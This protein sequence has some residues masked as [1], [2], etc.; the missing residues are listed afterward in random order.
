M[1]DDLPKYK[2]R[3]R[4]PE[5]P[6][7]AMKA[8]EADPAAKQPLGLKAKCE[9]LSEEEAMTS[10]DEMLEDAYGAST[11]RRRRRERLGA[12]GKSVFA[13]IFAAAA[14]TATFL[15]AHKYEG[16]PVMQPMDW[17]LPFALSAALSA[18]ICLQS[19]HFW[20]D[21]S[22]WLAIFG[23]LLAGLLCKGNLFLLERASFSAVP[24][25]MR[26][27]TSPLELN[28]L[29]VTVKF[30]EL[31]SIPATKQSY[32]GFSN[33]EYR[34]AFQSISRDQWRPIFKQFLSADEMRGVTNLNMDDKLN[35]VIQRLEVSRVE[36]WNL[37][38]E[39]VESP[40]LEFTALEAFVAPYIWLI[41][42]F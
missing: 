10:T 37:L 35:L 30:N 11:R 23:I 26:A 28:Q 6:E 42:A 39:T 14:I 25:P 31:R 17:Y 7:E 5:R 24:G 12:F 32:T 36:A 13:L 21:R 38:A 41:G 9:K 16:W 29:Y 15:Y 33:G 4:A 8:A 1:S 27:L 40:P 18:W 3:K 20:R 2:L 22:R 19:F 34:E